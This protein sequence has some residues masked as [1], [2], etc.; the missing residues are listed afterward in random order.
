MQNTVEEVG[1]I[2]TRHI[3]YC[4]REDLQ[5]AYRRTHDVEMT[6]DKEDNSGEER[7]E[8]HEDERQVDTAGEIRQVK[9][10]EDNTVQLKACDDQMGGGGT[11]TVQ[12]M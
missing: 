4:P 7:Q 9:I 5:R 6:S 3:V 11:N 2:E 8:E 1:L 12:S 10:R